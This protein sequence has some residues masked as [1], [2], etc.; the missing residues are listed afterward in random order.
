MLRPMSAAHDVVTVRQCQTP[1]G[2][3]LSFIT[4]GGPVLPSIKLQRPFTWAPSQLCSRRGVVPAVRTRRWS[5]STTRMS[6]A[7]DDRADAKSV[8]ATP[9]FG[10]DDWAL[11]DKAGWAALEGGRME[12]VFIDVGSEDGVKR[13]PELDHPALE[14]VMT[15]L[16]ASKFRDTTIN[17]IAAV[18]KKVFQ[19]Y[20]AMVS[21]VNVTHLLDALLVFWLA[22]YH[23]VTKRQFLPNSKDLTRIRLVFLRATSGLGKTHFFNLLCRLPDLI[24]AYDQLPAREQAKYAERRLALDWASA[25]VVFPVTFNGLC[26]LDVSRESSLVRMRAKK[27]DGSAPQLPVLLRFLFVGI[28]PVHTAQSWV[29]FLKCCSAALSKGTLTAVDVRTA[30]DDLFERLQARTP[31]KAVILLVDEVGACEA[32]PAGP[33]KPYSS[34]GEGVR[35]FL[36]D[37]AEQRRGPAAFSTILVSLMYLMTTPVSRRPLRSGYSLKLIP[38]QDAARFLLP[39]L[40]EFYSRGSQMVIGGKVVFGD[41]RDKDHPITSRVGRQR[42]SAVARYCA[43]LTCGHSRLLANLDVLLR[44]HQTVPQSLTKGANISALVEQAA[45]G[46]GLTCTTLEFAMKSRDLVGI[47]VLGSL[48]QSSARVRTEEGLSTLDKLGS[49]GK[50]ILSG[51]FMCR[52]LMPASSF[53]TNVRFSRLKHPLIQALKNMTA[54]TAHDIGTIWEDFHLWWEVAASQARALDGSNF[55]RCTLSEVYA[56]SRSGDGDDNIA[57]TL[58]TKIFCGSSDIL[59]HVQLDFATPKKAVASRDLSLLVKMAKEPAKHSQLL[60]TVWRTSTGHPAV[61]G[62]IFLRCSVA[63]GPYPKDAL[64]M[65]LISLKSTAPGMDGSFNTNVEVP[66]GWSQVRGIFG[67]SWEEWKQRVAMLYVL[68]RGCSGCLDDVGESD[69]SRTMVCGLD[70]LVDLYGRMISDVG[71]SLELLRKAEL[72]Y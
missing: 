65:V 53:V 10:G 14:E 28:F 52:P 4:Y 70:G 72:L 49:D 24:Q 11:L 23:A 50:I 1:L 9:G 61:D 8:G 40:R 43:S 25:N 21:Y 47:L 18:S 69:A 20:P 32:L 13:T 27:H 29:L 71:M 6:A 30:A 48:M 55:T 7:S 19:P 26:R 58:S 46:S 59:R 66:R 15:E 12:P 64:V 31:G 57:P 16:L 67:P 3:S 34:G 37:Y 44:T 41:M 51:P 35:S 36:S 42:L 39:A 60:R 17:D 62:V 63:Y 38:L 56:S 68:R 2:P 5:S 54:C 33:F 45:E 22:V